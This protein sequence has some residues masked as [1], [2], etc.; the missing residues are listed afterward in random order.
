MASSSSSEAASANS[1]LT[2]GQLLTRGIQGAQFVTKAPSPNDQHVQTRLQAALSDL[3]VCSKLIN[4]LGILSTNETIEDVHTRDLRCLLVDSFRA[5]LEVLAK[6]KGGQERLQWLDRAKTHLSQFVT[7]V[8]QYG[9]VSDAQRKAFSGTKHSVQDPS[10]RRESK[11]A[12][13]KL[14]REV[15]GKLEELKRRK[16][17]QRTRARAS[18]IA[19]TSSSNPHDDRDDDDELDFDSD[20]DDTEVARPLFVN[21]IMLHYVQ[22]QTELSSIDQE[23]ELL[24]HGMAMSDLPSHKATGSSNDDKRIQNQEQQDTT[25][26]LDKLS[27]SN[28]GPLLNPEGK[29]LRPFTILPSRESALSTKLR[30][31]SEVFRPSHTLPTMTIDEFLEIEQERG[32]ILQGGGPNSS[33]AVE[34]AKQ[35]ERGLKEQDTF[36]GY[37]AED[38]QTMKDREWDEYKD[39]HRRGEGNMMNRG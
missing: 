3:T 27:I 11:I 33:E 32:N 26:R 29:V 30:L 16:R 9:I 2:L 28:D 35:D 5:Q 1:D 6:T 34:Q 10:T 19:S 20:D 38:R 37:E 7:V 18:I 8:E 24:K 13:F 25:W 39:S 23:L 21:L 4:H 17:A 22:A 15:K 12:Q 31:K 14:E 36:E